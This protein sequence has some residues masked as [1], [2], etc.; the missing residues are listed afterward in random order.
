MLI[1][2]DKSQQH[3]YSE[4]RWRMPGNL[5][6]LLRRLYSRF[7]ANRCS[8]SDQGQ[9]WRRDFWTRWKYQREKKRRKKAKENI[10]SD[11]LMALVEFAPETSVDATT[12][13]YWSATGFEWQIWASL[14]GVGFGCSQC[15]S[16]R[17]RSRVL[18]PHARGTGWVE[19]CM[20]AGWWGCRAGA[21]ESAGCSGRGWW[22]SRGM[23]GWRWM[24][25]AGGWWEARG[26]V[27]AWIWIF[28]PRPASRHLPRPGWKNVLADVY[29]AFF[30][31][32]EKVWSAVTNQRFSKWD[33]VLR[34]RTSSKL[35][36]ATK[37]SISSLTYKYYVHPHFS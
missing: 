25:C 26:E 31:Q 13:T 21:P 36:A 11:N 3:K 10:F 28:P 18:I 19:A 34:R 9:N 15:W 35:G 16:G 32:T 37:C 8:I 27:G 1:R 12:E 29:F 22:W 23:E 2:L 33:A 6:V 4:L 30:G 24:V 20:G 14:V 7:K 5:T 17:W